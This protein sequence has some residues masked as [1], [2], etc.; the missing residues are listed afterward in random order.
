MFKAIF[1]RRREGEGL[2]YVCVCKDIHIKYG[3]FN[4]FVSYAST[5]YF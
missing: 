5:P 4:L 1:S 2:V 3:H